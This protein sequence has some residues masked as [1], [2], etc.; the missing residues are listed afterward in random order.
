MKGIAVDPEPSVPF[1]VEA[2]E[3][4]SNDQNTD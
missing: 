2:L 3:A 4:G 1:S